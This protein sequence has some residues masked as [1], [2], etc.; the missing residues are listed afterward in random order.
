MIF[1][2]IVTVYP[3]SDTHDPLFEAYTF[4]ISRIIDYREY[5]D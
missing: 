3:Y 2:H 4:T 1:Y 5:N